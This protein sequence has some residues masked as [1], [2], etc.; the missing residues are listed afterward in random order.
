MSR[1]IDPQAIASRASQVTNDVHTLATRFGLALDLLEQW[2]LAH[3]TDRHLVVQSRTLLQPSGRA[4]DHLVVRDE[5][6]GPAVLGDLVDRQ[7]VSD[8]LL[9]SGPMQAVQGDVSIGTLAHGLAGVVTRLPV[10][11]PVPAAA[12]PQASEGG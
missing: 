8:A 6:P 11:G 7:A 2:A 1:Q 3:P 4:V 12:G 9:T 5:P 10:N